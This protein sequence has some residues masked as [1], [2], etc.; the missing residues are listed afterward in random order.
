MAID[1]IRLILDQAEEQFFRAIRLEQ[2][3]IDEINEECEFGDLFDEFDV[4][5]LHAWLDSLEPTIDEL[6][7][8]D[9]TDYGFGHDA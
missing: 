8:R 2:S 9:L 3:E 7:S 4:E 6:N 5:A 1:A